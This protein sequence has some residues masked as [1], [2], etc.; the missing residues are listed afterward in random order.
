[1]NSR[2]VH[3]IEAESYRLLAARMDLSSMPPPVAAIV[4]RVAHATADLDLAASLVAPEH[5][6]DAG[7]RAIASG[8][9]VVCDVEMLRAGISTLESC[10]H[11][12]QCEPLAGGF[13]TRSARGIRLAA[14]AHPRGAIFA[15]AC[16]PSALEELS[17]LISRGACVPSLVVALPVGFVGAAVSKARA[18][19]VCT[20]AGVAVISNVGE[21]G[22]SAAGASVLNA[23]ARL[24]ARGEPDG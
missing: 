17:D 14:E 13:P 18:V 22:G 23:L 3:P 8:A 1:M 5:A 19:Q 2:A 20:D 6:V 7:V 16:A 21:R 12:W 24:A 11:L 15:V 9:Q 4:S 10:C